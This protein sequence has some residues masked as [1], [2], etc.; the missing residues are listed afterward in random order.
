MKR[1]ALLALLML[2]FVAGLVAFAPLSAALKASGAAQRGLSWTQAEGTVLSGR[3]VDLALRGISYGDADL[4][5]S[6]GGLLTGNL[7]YTVNWTGPQG[8]GRAKVSAGGGGRV[9]LRDFAV[10]LDLAQ[11]EQAAL[12][13]R[14]SGGRLDLSGP[15]LRF[16][17]EGCISADGSARSDVL[18]RNQDILGSGWTPMQGALRCE[19]GTLVFPMASENQTGTRFEATLRLAPHQP[20]QFEARVSGLVPRELAFALPIAGFTPQGQDFVYL[21]STS[22]MSA[23]K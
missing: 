23:P 9:A 8:A 6:P 4:T 19:G 18:E 1:M 12:W 21:F 7:Q 14:Q 15:S 5:F 13:I 11:L 3:V 22:D 2:G 10:S 17:P 16:G 20:G